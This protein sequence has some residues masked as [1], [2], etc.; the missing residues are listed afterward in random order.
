MKLSLPTKSQWVSVLKN[1]VFAAVSALVAMYSNEPSL[2]VPCMFI[3][4][5]AEK[6]LLAPTA[7]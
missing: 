6:L 7:Q 5:V 2:A 4:K 1:T 3:L